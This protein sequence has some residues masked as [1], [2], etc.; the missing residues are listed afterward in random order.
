MKPSK[1]DPRASIRSRARFLRATD[2]LS[3]ITLDEPT[4]EKL[5]AVLRRTG[6]TR[7]GLVRRLIREAYKA[8]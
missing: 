3:A 5:W 6:E 7:A 4:A 2:I 1:P 8:L